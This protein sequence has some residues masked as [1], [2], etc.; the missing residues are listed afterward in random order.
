MPVLEADRTAVAAEVRLPE[1]FEGIHGEIVKTE[2]MSVYAGV[3]ANMLKDQLAVYG[4]STRTGRSWV[5]LLFAI[6]QTDDPGRNRRPDVAFTTFERWPLNRPIPYRG[7]PI[8]VIPDLAV[9]VVSPTD[10]SEDVI[11]KANE[12]LRGGVRLVWLVFPREQQVHAY[13]GPKSVRIFTVDDQ[14]DGG[15]ILP[16]LRIDM[17]SLFPPM[18]NRPVPVDDSP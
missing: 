7:N 15:D 16:G 9:E 17:A 5:E 10:D 13:T 11:A 14:L 4:Q 3:V 6:P 12:Y 1:F 18:S 8:D 2:P